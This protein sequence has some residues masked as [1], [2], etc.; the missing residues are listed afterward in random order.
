MNKY[1]NKKVVIDGIEFDS[2]KEGNYYIKLKAMTKAGLIDAVE[3]QPE[4]ILI[5]SF[6]KNGKTYRK[7][8]YKADFKYI[9]KITNRI[10]VVDV[11]GFKTKE[12][13]LKKKLFEYQYPELEIKEI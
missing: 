12:Y 5:P 2:K 11:K 8:T 1:H 3:L 7:T 4:F 9:D 13:M 10:I 6:K